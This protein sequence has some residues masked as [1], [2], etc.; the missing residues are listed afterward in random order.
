MWFLEAA[1]TQ[2]ELHGLRQLGLHCCMVDDIL[3]LKWA[4][5]PHCQLLRLFLEG[6]GP[7]WTATPSG[8]LGRLGL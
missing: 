3:D 5:E 7:G 8:Q 2:V 4:I 6:L 1:S